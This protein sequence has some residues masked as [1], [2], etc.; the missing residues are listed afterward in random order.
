VVEISDR[1][2]VISSAHEAGAPLWRL[3]QHLTPPASLSSQRR[4]CRFHAD[5]LSVTT[6]DFFLASGIDPNGMGAN[7]VVAFDPGERM[8][9]V[10][11]R[12]G[13]QPS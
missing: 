3:R 1:T 11:Q 2:V 7:A 9:P 5:L 13:T 12:P 4:S 8:G 6:E 10:R